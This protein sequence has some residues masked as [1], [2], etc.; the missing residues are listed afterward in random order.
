MKW[1][2]R[3]LSALTAALVTTLAAS[4]VSV[5]FVMFSSGS[6]PGRH[7]VYFGALFFEVRAG[8]AGALDIGVGL[9]SLT[10]LVLSAVLMATF[11]IAVFAALDRLRVYRRHLER[12]QTT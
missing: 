11:V 2:I 6:Q 4:V 8:T 1:F 3:V 9:V 12:E 10:P 7:L 5:I